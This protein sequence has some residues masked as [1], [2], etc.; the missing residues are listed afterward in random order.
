MARWSFISDKIINTYNRLCKT[1]NHHSPISHQELIN[2]IRAFV[3]DTNCLMISPNNNRDQILSTIKSNTTLWEQLLH[4]AGGKLEINKCKFTI[5]TWTFDT[6]GTPRIDNSI[7]STTI[8][9]NDS[10]TNTPQPIHEIKPKEAYKLLGIHMA[11]DG[12]SIAQTQHMETK[13]NNCVQLWNKCQLNPQEAT[14]RL[15][16]IIYPTL[17]YG[18]AATSIP[19]VKLDQAQAKITNKILPTLGYNR[20][21]PRDVVYGPTQYGGLGIHR[22]STEQG[23]AHTKHLLGSLLLENKEQTE[24][25]A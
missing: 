5:L 16:S 6:N 11:I 12:N 19:D 23:I 10:E 2:R 15:Y 4:Q 3:D 22:L 9:I 14:V 20:H 21:F 24:I 8:D 1:H 7:P 13:C 18:L 17:K 25:F